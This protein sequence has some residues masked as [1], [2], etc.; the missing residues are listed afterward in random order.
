MVGEI[1]NSKKE[2]VTSKEG[3]RRFT[4]FELKAL[5][6]LMCNPRI[7]AHEFYAKM[8]PFN[9]FKPISSSAKGATASMYLNR[10]IKLK[11]V[12]RF[13]TK[14]RYCY[15]ITEQGEKALK[16]KA[17]LDVLNKTVLFV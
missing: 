17:R 2:K 7:K 1:Q 8:W 5:K 3:V 13:G 11:L 16:P 6:I 12:E 9:R 10:L 15:F 14:R 4:P